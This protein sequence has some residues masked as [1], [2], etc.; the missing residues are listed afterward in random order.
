MVGKTLAVRL[1]ERRNH[2]VAKVVN[3]S[4]AKANG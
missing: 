1:G 3:S 4:F 2:D